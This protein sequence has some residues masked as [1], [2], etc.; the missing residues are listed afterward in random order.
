MAQLML[1]S[2][3]RLG[4]IALFAVSLWGCVREDWGGPKGAPPPKA[5]APPRE[6]PAEVDGS[7]DADG[8]PDAPLYPGAPGAPGAPGTGGPGAPNGNGTSS[9]AGPGASGDGTVVPR[10]DAVLSGGKIPGFDDAV[11]GMRSTLKACVDGKGNSSARVEITAKVGPKGN[12]LKSDR[13]GGSSFA[14]GAVTCLMKRIDAAQFKKPTEGAP[15]ITF[16]VRMASE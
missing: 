4:V 5:D 2:R 3:A 13:V 6:V 12:V 10:V 7:D 16:R 9:D 15:K 14:H 1:G 8:P 11:A